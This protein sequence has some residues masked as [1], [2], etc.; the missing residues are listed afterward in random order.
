[1]S[2]DGYS[3]GFISGP[4]P[5]GMLIKKGDEEEGDTKGTFPPT[6]TKR[7][8]KALVFMKLII[9]KVGR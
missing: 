2:F 8:K 7:E 4:L 6:H 9:V 5:P 3:L 1:M